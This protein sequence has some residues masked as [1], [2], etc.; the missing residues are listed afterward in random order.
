MRHV[1]RANAD[2]TTTSGSMQAVC[3]PHER[4]DVSRQLAIIYTDGK[5]QLKVRAQRPWVMAD[6]GQEP[7][8]AAR[9]ILD[10][11]QD[12]FAT[13]LAFLGVRPSTRELCRL[14]LVCTFFRDIIADEATWQILCKYSWSVDDADLSADWPRLESFR[15]LYAVLEVWAPRQGFHQLIDAFPW[16]A[17][18]LLSF[19]KGVFVGELLHHDPPAAGSTK[20]VARAP[21]PVLSVTFAT[22]ADITEP[23]VESGVAPMPAWMAP[24]TR[25]VMRWCGQPLASCEITHSPQAHPRHLGDVTNFFI[26]HQGARFAQSLVPNYVRCRQYL[27]LRV[28]SAAAAEGTTRR[29]LREWDPWQQ[30]VEEDLWPRRLEEILSDASRFGGEL[31]LG[32]VDG[33]QLTL[34]EPMGGAAAAADTLALRP[35]LYVGNY[36]HSFYGDFGRESLLIELH[37]CVCGRLC[38]G[39][40]RA[41]PTPQACICNAHARS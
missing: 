37:K 17:L 31:T 18:L 13:I 34:A 27:V 22:S 26:G 15:S 29:Q 40:L 1:G 6:E 41:M 9:T 14:S 12:S 32:L 19:R 23:A 28:G 2:A 21:V 20:C 36:A 11:S 3:R 24:V 10:V 5:W 30:R 33:P 7:A 35:G 16:G 4:F 8:E 38:R 39:P 25:A